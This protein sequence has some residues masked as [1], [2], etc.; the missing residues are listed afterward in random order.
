M[1]SRRACF[2]LESW[3]NVNQS[4]FLKYLDHAN[5]CAILLTPSPAGGEPAAGGGGAGVRGGARQQVLGLRELRAAV[6]LAAARP[7]PRPE[8]RHR[9]DA[10]GLGLLLRRHQQQGFSC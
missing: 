2:Y 6:G 3:C 4:I 5:F 10:Q 8:H 1:L 9:R 7:A